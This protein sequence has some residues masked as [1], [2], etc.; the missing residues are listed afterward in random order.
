M[1]YSKRRYC[2]NCHYPLAYQA[3]F[4]AHCGQKD[5]DGRVPVGDFLQQLWF[6]IFKL[7]SKY[8]LILWHLL[9]PGKVSLAYFQGKQKRY[10][11]PVQFFFVV[12]FFFIVALGKVVSPGNLMV[13]TREGGI[14]LGTPADST[15]KTE[16]L[17]NAVRRMHEEERRYLLVETLRARYDS[18]PARL[19]SPQSRQ[20]VDSLL[21]AVLDSSGGHV[22][23]FPLSMWGKDFRIAAIDLYQ[24]QPEDIFEKYGANDWRTRLMLR[25]QMKMITDPTSIIGAYLGNLTWTIFALIAVMSLVLRVL[26]WRQKRYYVEHFVFLLH[27]HTADFLLLTLAIVL[28]LFYPVGWAGWALLFAWLSLSTLVA[29][30]VF[31]RQGWWRT[32]FKWTVYSFVYLISFW[33]LFALGALVVF[34]IF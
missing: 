6:R 3:R 8:F 14:M 28:H 20:A 17:A 19:R 1:K 13:N 21:N 31:Y 24:Q 2:K 10:P 34:F 22:D 18:L 4:C 29:M 27:Q 32:F 16:T 33:V 12:V 9:I 23:T 30:R 7:E 15:M 5:T 11:P 25:Q 26:Y